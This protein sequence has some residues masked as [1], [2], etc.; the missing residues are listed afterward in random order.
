MQFQ[1]SYFFPVH[2]FVVLRILI[3]DINLPLVSRIV[4]VRNR[5]VGTGYIMGVEFIDMPQTDRK[6][7]ISYLNSLSQNEQ[8]APIQFF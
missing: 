8:M 2:E 3:K 6:R 5:P 7:L 1:T 4:R